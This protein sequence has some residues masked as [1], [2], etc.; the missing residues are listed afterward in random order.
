MNVPS[1][2]KRQLTGFQSTGYNS[3]QVMGEVFHLETRYK[4]IDYLGAG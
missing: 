1:A 4:I 2:P 3:W